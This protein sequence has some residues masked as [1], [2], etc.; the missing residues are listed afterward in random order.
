[1]LKKHRTHVSIDR[2]RTY[3]SCMHACNRRA[4]SRTSTSK[5]LH[6]YSC[7]CMCTCALTCVH[8]CSAGAC[9]GPALPS[10]WLFLQGSG[11]IFDPC[12]VGLRQL[13]RSEMS[14]C[15]TEFGKGLSLLLILEGPVPVEVT[16]VQKLPKL[17]KS[18]WSSLEFPC[19]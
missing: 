17:I 6:R 2:Y 13:R 4:S 19:A 15:V 10:R 5:C 1:M 14:S 7:I 18:N 11:Q 3:D 8:E 9:R 12:P 16:I